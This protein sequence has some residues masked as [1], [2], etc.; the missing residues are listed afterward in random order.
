MVVQPSALRDALGTLGGQ[1]EEQQKNCPADK[2]DNSDDDIVANN[3]EGGDS[4]DA[5]NER[6]CWKEGPDRF[7][8]M[9][10]EE[11]DGCQTASFES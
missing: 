9:T 11:I 8:L 1:G 6:H 5:L 4:E 10:E 3:S 2:A 7:P